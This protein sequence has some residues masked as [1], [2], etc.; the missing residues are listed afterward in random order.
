MLTQNFFFQAD[1]YSAE[2]KTYKAKEINIRG[3]VC[4]ISKVQQT[5]REKKKI[6][7]APLLSSDGQ[8]LYPS[9]Q[10]EFLPS[11]RFDFGKCVVRAIPVQSAV[12][13]L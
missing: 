12:N 3:R 11:F 9:F 5:R 8:V 6:F 1:V 10:E 13:E 2:R 7:S 4:V